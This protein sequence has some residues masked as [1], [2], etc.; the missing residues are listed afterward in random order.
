MSMRNL[1]RKSL[2][3]AAMLLTAPLAFCQFETAAVLGTVFDGN[4]AVVRGARVDLVN[5][6]TGL[7]QQAGTDSE[8]NYQF[9]EVR[10][11]QYQVRVEAP[12]FKK[13]ETPQFRVTVGARERVNVT[14]QLGEVNQTVEVNSS[15]AIVE[16]ES[17][18]RDQ[19]IGQED[20]QNLPLNGRDSAAL[21]LL[22]PGVRNSYAL[23]KREAFV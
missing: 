21:A 7:A 6:E 11:G 10:L 4:G 9:L 15:A 14:L 22:A 17:S 1:F 2:S 23:S 12:G 16:Q 19:V 13:A 5:H 3:A 18:E 20:I 8:G